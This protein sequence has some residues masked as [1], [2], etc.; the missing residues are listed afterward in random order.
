MAEVEVSIYVP[1]ENGDLKFITDADV[2][3]DTNSALLID[4]F[5]DENPRN[6]DDV[7]VIIDQDA[8][9]VELVE[10][11]D[12]EP[13]QPRRKLIV[14][15]GNNG[16]SASDEE[17]APRPPKRSAPKKATTRKAPAAKPK[18]TAK[19]KP[20][21]ATKKPAP[22]R[23]AAKKPAPKKRGGSFGRKSEDE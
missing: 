17:E 15:G 10:V 20:R 18:A 22:K 3:E 11:E 19:A 13:V 12:R 14:R 9:T 7:F 8:G 6:Q 4:A 23:A 2:D 5:L 1:K 16:G 21:A